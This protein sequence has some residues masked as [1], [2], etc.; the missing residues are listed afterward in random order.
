MS[1]VTAGLAV[2]GVV[3]ILIPIVIFLLWRQRRTP[4][5]WAAMR[6]L[7][8]AFRKHRRRLQIEQLL[9]LAIRCLIIALLGFALARPL[10]EGTGL[11]DGG[12][13]RTVYLVVD[14]GIASGVEEEPG[15]TALDKHVA[16][17]LA[18]VE[19]L[20][21][22]DRVGV[23]TTA[24]PARALLDPPSTDRAAVMD[25]LRGLQSSSAPSDLPGALERLHTA[26][27]RVEP[28]QDKVLVYMLSEYRAGSAALDEALPPSLPASMDDATARVLLRSVPPATNPIDNVQITALTPSRSLVIADAID[29]TGQVTVRLARQGGDLERGFTKVRVEGDGLALIEPKI[30]EWAPGQS[31]ARADFVLDVTAQRDR[32]TGLRAVID[33]DALAADNDRATVVSLRTQVRALLIDRRSFGFEPAIDRMT[34]GQWMRRALAPRLEG[35][36]DIVEVEPAALDVADLRT[37]D[38]AVLPRPDLVTDGGWDALRDYVDGGGLL[39]LTPPAD[40]N[41]HRWSDQLRERMGLRWQLD[42]E[43]TDF[44]DGLAL[45]DEQPRSALLHMISGDLAALCRPVV[46]RRALLVDTT[47]SHVDP[48]LVFADGRPL[49]IAGTPEA[50]G[51]PAPPTGSSAGS[52]AEPGAPAPDEVSGM[53]VYLATAPQLDWTTLPGKPLMVPLLQ[54]VIRQGLSLIRAG[55]AHAVGERPALLAGAAARAIVTPE[56]E[57]IAIDRARR[58]EHALDERGLYRIVDLAGQD[59]GALAVNVNASAARTDVQSATAVSAWLERSGPWSFYDPENVGADLQGADGGSPLAGVLLLIV[60]GLLLL[61]TLLARW[62]SHAYTAAGA[63]KGESERGLGPTMGSLATTTKRATG[64]AGVQP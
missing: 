42:R 30:V 11:L 56:G 29:G 24:R 3:G 58:P 44:P 55:S 47:A 13:S 7:M 49:M 10:L 26:L 39:L 25:L 2:A 46:T 61:E 23:I 63:I 22:G 41:V 31:E 34:A 43:A 35:A 50:G 6:F 12:G 60:L 51:A 62:F 38:V 53:V 9:L 32:D 27:E 19:G 17:A 36:V 40:L 64:L 45:A 8:E 18:I 5:P 48:V 33:N 16:G 54:E 21:A 15:A 59:V 37:A 14:D 4:V 20:D 28:D 1:F 52:L 57:R